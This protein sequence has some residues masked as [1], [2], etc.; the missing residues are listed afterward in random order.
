[1]LTAEI[2]PYPSYRMSPA[3]VRMAF[4][5]ENLHAMQLVTQ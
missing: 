1:M 4:G 2:L 5:Y 3:T